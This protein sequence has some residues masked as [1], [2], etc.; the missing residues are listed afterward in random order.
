MP[1]L[2]YSSLSNALEIAG[3]P[4]NGTSEV[5]TVTLSSFSAC[6]LTLTYKGASTT[7]AQYLLP[8]I[9]ARFTTRFPE[10]LTPQERHYV[11]G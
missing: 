8:P 11:A 7:I 1:D 2:P 6:S 10:R 3:T 9:L 4:S 5:Q